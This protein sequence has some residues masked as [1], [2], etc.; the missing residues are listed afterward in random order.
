MKPQFKIG[1]TASYRAC[2]LQRSG[3]SASNP[4]SMKP[5][6]DAGVG[7]CGSVRECQ[8]LVSFKMDWKPTLRSAP[9]RAAPLRC[10]GHSRLDSSTKHKPVLPS[11]VGGALSNSQIRNQGAGTTNWA[12]SCSPLPAPHDTR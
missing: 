8:R 6:V 10:S 11:P 5:G 7:H 3:A 4:F 9:L 12:F 1:L 2:P